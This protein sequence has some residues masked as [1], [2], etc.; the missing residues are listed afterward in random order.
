MTKRTKA[1]SNQPPQEDAPVSCEL[2][3]GAERAGGRA[4]GALLSD[5]L[6]IVELAQLSFE[7]H[8]EPGLSDPSSVLRE[9]LRATAEDAAIV[10]LAGAHD[11]GTL[12]CQMAV[13]RIELRA[14][15]ALRIHAFR[16]KHGAVTAPA[17]EA[18][19]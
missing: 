16:L 19:P 13:R 14:G 1:R 5:A 12:E 8:G 10:S 18:H 4:E 3:R 15:L 2:R 6:A 11:D 9:A 17:E 7:A